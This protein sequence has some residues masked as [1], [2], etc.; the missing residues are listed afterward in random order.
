MLAA[1]TTLSA[2]LIASPSTTTADRIAADGG[3]LLG[4][5]HRC[6][7]ATDRVVRAGQLV[8]DLIAAAAGDKE[9]RAHAVTRFAK[10]FLVS[11]FPDQTKETPIASCKIVGREFARLEQ[12]QLRLAGASPDHSTGNSAVGHYPPGAGQ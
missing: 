6:G 11:A 12:H 2:L 8:Q 5:A 4:N 7:V 1:A 3:F 9:Q 10:F